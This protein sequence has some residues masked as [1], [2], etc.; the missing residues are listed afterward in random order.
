MFVLSKRYHG[1]LRH[2]PKPDV[3]FRK[4]SKITAPSLNDFCQIMSQYADLLV[5]DCGE[6]HCYFFAA[7]SKY[8]VGNIQTLPHIN[9]ARIEFFDHVI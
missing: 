8:I 5:D 6:P 9:C 1:S 4:L 2:L 3:D 7:D